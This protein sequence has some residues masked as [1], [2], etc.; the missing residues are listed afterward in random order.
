MLSFQWTLQ[1]SRTMVSFL[2]PQLAIQVER[3]GFP[4]ISQG[5]GG[6]SPCFGIWGLYVF[7]SSRRDHLVFASSK[8]DVEGIEMANGTSDG[9]RVSSLRVLGCSKCSEAGGGWDTPEDASTPQHTVSVFQWHSQMKWNHSH[10]ADKADF[11]LV[12]C[13]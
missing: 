9:A 7:L 12:A 6:R 3:L 1:R 10:C 11:C 8:A 13:C 4:G 5:S 2:I